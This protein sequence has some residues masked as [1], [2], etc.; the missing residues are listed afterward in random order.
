[1]DGCRW[2]VLITIGIL[3]IGSSSSP[4]FPRESESR[5]VRYLDG[6][7]NF[8]ADNSSS[9]DAGFT[10]SWFKQPLSTVSC[11]FWLVGGGGGGGG[12]YF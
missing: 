12:V 4:L 10:N 8:R 1:M 11:F 2:E 7:W 3:V 6:F 9:R 5:E